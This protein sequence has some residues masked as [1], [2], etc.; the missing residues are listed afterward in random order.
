MALSIHVGAHKTASTHLQTTLRLLTEPLLKAGIHYQGPKQLRE[1]KPQLHPSLAEGVPF[2]R[3]RTR[4]RRR[5]TEVFDVWP[6]AI[7]SEENILGTLRSDRLMGPTGLYPEAS[8]RVMRLMQITSHQPAVLFMSIREPLSFLQS[9]FLM[10]VRGGWELF[11]EDYTRN[12]DPAAMLWTDLAERLLEVPGVVGLVV[13]RYEDYAAVRPE[14]LRALMP[15]SVAELAQNPPPAVV[16]M[17]LS[18][19]QEVVRSVEGDTSITLQEAAERA[20][21]MFPRILGDDDGH[22]VD[23]ATVA[24]VREAYAADVAALRRV[25]GVRMLG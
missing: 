22:I 15:E 9:A 3:S 10:Q 16:G 11:F 23:A 2:R 14:I 25:D 18:A 5:M 20:K 19:Y 4:L 24:R 1:A 6:Q 17:S 21:T 8:Q 12:F 13:W 7:L